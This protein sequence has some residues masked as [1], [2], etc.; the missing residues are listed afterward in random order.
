MSHILALALFFWE[1]KKAITFLLVNLLV[2]I[3]HLLQDS[4]EVVNR[5]P[6]DWNMGLF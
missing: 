6:M 4:C 1:P 3:S 5:D 2:C